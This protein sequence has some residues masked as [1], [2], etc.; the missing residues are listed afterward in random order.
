MKENNKL[1]I[2]RHSCSHLLA[3]AVLK[4]YPKTKFGIGPAIENGFYYDFDFEKPITEADL[5]KISQ[6]MIKIVKQKLSFEKKEIAIAEAQILFKNQPY[7][8]ELIEDLKKEGIKKVSIYKLGDFTDLCLGPH[9][10]NADQINSFKLLSLAGA[11]WRGSEQNKMLTRIY[12][13]CF[14]NQ[15]DLDEHL[16]IIE[17]IKKRDHRKLGPKLEL[18][19]MHP[20]AP[21]MPYWLPKGVTIINELVDFWRKE[22]NKRGYQEIK[23]PLLNKKELYV[24][25][26]H[27]QHY[28]EEM[29]IS[30][31]G[32][33]EIYALKPMNCPN[34]M[35]VFQ[36]KLRSYKDLPLRIADVDILHRNERSG[37]LNGLFRVREFSQD[38]AHIFITEQ[39]I[40]S[41]YKK[42]LEITELFYSVFDLDYSLRLGTRPE[43]F[44]GDKSSWDKAEKELKQILKESNKNYSL[45]EGDGAFYGPKIDI[46]MKDSLGREWQMGT[47]QLDFQIP[48]KFKVKYIDKDGKQKTPVVIHRVIYGSLERF[49]GILIEHYNGAFPVW[50]APVQVAVLTI[51]DKQQ[52]YA[53]ELV[54]K[55]QCENIRVE[56]DNHN[57]TFG[58]K[59]RDAQIAKIPYMIIIGDKEIKQ[60]TINIRTRN[61]KIIGE[62]SSEKFI[63]LIKEDIANKRQ[64]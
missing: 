56:I 19:F 52:D 13:T 11:Y 22:H 29:F 9:I 63:S 55:L 28:Q 4:L 48:K 54:K 35:V 31:T 53:M 16:K 18:F 2:M 42:I 49:M 59:I 45:L 12:G 23:S 20:T 5:D 8:L 1:K 33:K 26:G 57:Q 60:N 40:K 36:N 43:K 61:E 30:K 46:L 6:Q 47:I 7:K 17:E 14:D 51:S 27:W 50:I 44:M 39:Q 58:A 32:E 25:S 64:I 21:G 38:D 3:T 15:K 37:T 10:E 24:N 62:M 34:A 41:E